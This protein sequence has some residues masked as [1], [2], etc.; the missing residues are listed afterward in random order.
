MELEHYEIILRYY[1]TKY[2]INFRNPCR[3]ILE[4][5]PSF[6]LQNEIFF[7]IFKK[8]EMDHLKFIPGILDEEELDNF[9]VIFF[10]REPKIETLFEIAD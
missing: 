9:D 5:V 10:V 3:N 4:K 7:E 2:G 8:N 6:R 1:G